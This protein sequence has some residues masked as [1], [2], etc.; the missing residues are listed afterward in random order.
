MEKSLQEFVLKFNGFSLDLGAIFVQ[1]WHQKGSKIGWKID[2]IWENVFFEKSCSRCSGG[3]IFEVL[4]L[5]V[6]DT[7]RWI[8]DQKTKPKMVCL[9]V[10]SFDGFL[11]IFKAKL[12]QVGMENWLKFYPKRYQIYDGKKQRLEPSWK[13]LGVVLGPLER[14]TRVHA[15]SRVWPVA[16]AQR[17]PIRI[18]YDFPDHYKDI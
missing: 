18:L 13:R 4:E 3:S 16:G 11:Q 2:V 9:L 15:C 10:S 14:F 12:S 5:E 6:R 7:I 1:I 8:I 17:P